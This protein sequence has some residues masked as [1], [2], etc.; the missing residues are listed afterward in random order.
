MASWLPTLLSFL[1]GCAAGTAWVR[2]DYWRRERVLSALAGQ[3]P[4]PDWELGARKLEKHAVREALR[5][6]VYNAHDLQALAD[7]VRNR[8]R[9]RA[10]NA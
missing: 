5:G 3:A 2:Y 7:T 8:G 9:S 1:A 6:N 10:G 4:L